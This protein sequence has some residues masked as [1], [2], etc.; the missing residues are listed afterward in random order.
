MTNFAQWLTIDP[1][2]TLKYASVELFDWGC[3]SHFLDGASYDATPHPWSHHYNI[4]AHRC[5]Y[6]DDVMAYCIEHEIAHHV[7]E[8][9]LHDRPS[10]IL[11]GL[12]HGEPLSGPESAYE[13][14]MAQTLQRFARAAERPIV[15]DVNWDAM[16]A[17]FLETLP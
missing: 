11:W 3:T 15:G 4:I 17:R 5:G 13:E 10:R 8:E 16:R 6:G 1:V 9:F 14:L 7:V 12:A 2:V